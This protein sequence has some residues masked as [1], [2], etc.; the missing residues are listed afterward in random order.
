MTLSTCRQAPVSERLRTVQ[1]ITELLS[2]RRIL[3]PRKVRVRWVFRRSSKALPSRSAKVQ[4]T[5]MLGGVRSYPYKYTTGIRDD[6]CL[7]VFQICYCPQGIEP[8]LAWV[9]CGNRRRPVA[10]RRRPDRGSLP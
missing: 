2:L 9:E 8:K 3:P 6:Y 1:L 7:I 4:F 10:E 5:G